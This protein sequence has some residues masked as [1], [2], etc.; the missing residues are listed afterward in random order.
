MTLTTLRLSKS[1]KSVSLRKRGEGQPVLLVHGVGMQSAAWGPQF[2][3][4]SDLYHV[5]AV[6]LPGHG[7]SDRLAS[8]S[9]LPDF[10]H[11]LHDVAITLNLGPVAI[12]GH[13]MGA[14]IAAGFAAEYAD[15]V[16]RVALLNG[17][18]RRD[19]SASEAVIKRAAEIREGK[20]DLETPLSRWFGNSPADVA[21]RRQVAD[22]LGSMDR[23]GY[24]VAY[25]AFAHGDATYASEMSGVACPFLAIT[26]DAD[27]N[28]TPAMS[29]AMAAAVQNG[30]AIVIEGHRHMVNL[31]APD[32]VTAHLIDWLDQPAA[33]RMAQ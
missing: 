8:G 33:K 10:V 11:W 27:P 31:T 26:G 15:M 16:S 24:A 32:T 7:G 22:W 13:S 1:D 28:S 6:D 2:N 5:I 4:L 25:D 30:R 18:Y 17:V 21:A 9:Q 19:S 23:E 12:A 29:D 14:L 3:A 20:I